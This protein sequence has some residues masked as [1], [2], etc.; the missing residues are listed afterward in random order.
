MFIQLN[1]LTH[2]SLYTVYSEINVPLIIAPQKTN[3]AL[4][5][6]TPWLQIYWTERLISSLTDSHL[7][8]REGRR[9]GSLKEKKA[10]WPHCSYA[11]V[12]R[13]SSVVK[14]HH[15][16]FPPHVHPH[17]HSLLEKSTGEPTRH[18]CGGAHGEFLNRKTTYKLKCQREKIQELKTGRKYRAQNQ[19][20]RIRG[21]KSKEK[22]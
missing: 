16:H 22:T 9:R 3:R 13:L 10:D 21:S 12:W 20:E 19:K 4:S 17:C 2:G 18:L 15:H 14:W 7:F 1:I 8:G 6:I 11:V 5:V